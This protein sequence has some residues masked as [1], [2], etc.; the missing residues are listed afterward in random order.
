MEKILYHATF[1][2]YLPSIKKNGL[3]INSGNCSY[4]GQ[5]GDEAVYLA[6][7]YDIAEA[8]ADSA[9][10]DEDIMDTGIVVLEI[11]TALLDENKFGIDPNIILDEGEE[12]YSFV[13]FDNIPVEAISF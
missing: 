11:N 3:V 5:V 2:K 4:E 9:E 6:N 12:P 7:D 13:Y 8:F 10:V 1:E